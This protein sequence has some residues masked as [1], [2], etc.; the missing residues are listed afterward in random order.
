MKRDLGAS[1]LLA[2]C[3]EEVSPY[4][5]CGACASQHAGSMVGAAL[6]MGATKGHPQPCQCR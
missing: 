5:A 1:F 4:R 3:R 2:P 6:S